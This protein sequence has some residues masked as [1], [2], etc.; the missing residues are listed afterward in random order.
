VHDATA[1]EMEDC[2]TE[3]NRCEIYGKDISNAFIHHNFFGAG[4]QNGDY[5]IRT[6]RLWKTEISHNYFSGGTGNSHIDTISTVASDISIIGTTIEG[7]TGD[8]L[9]FTID[10]L[11]LNILAGENLTSNKV[12]NV[13]S[14]IVQRL[15]GVLV[16]GKLITEI[17]V[18][19]LTA[20]KSGDAYKYLNISDDL[21]A[22]IEKNNYGVVSTRVLSRYITTPPASADYSGSPGDW[23]MSA[24]GG[25]M[26]VCYAPNAWRAIPT[27]P[28]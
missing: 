24:N 10:T 17:P 26:Y 22:T 15:S 13:T 3:D 8:E 11:F 6:N 20:E 5:Q 23:A 9:T 25:T 2:Y 21:N 16:K 27:S 19:Q 1:F 7:N 12:E 4:H 14:A 28:F 18:R